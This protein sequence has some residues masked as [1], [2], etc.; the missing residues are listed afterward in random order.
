MTV[1]SLILQFYSYCYRDIH[2]IHVAKLF[3]WR[4]T[5]IH[6]QLFSRSH[7][8]YIHR[9]LIICCGHVFRLCIYRKLNSLE[10]PPPP[11]YW[12]I[13]QVTWEET[14]VNNIF[15]YNSRKLTIYTRFIVKVYTA[16]CSWPL[17]VVA[18]NNFVKNTS[19]HIWKQF[20]RVKNNIYSKSDIL[21]SCYS[22]STALVLQ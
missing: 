1:T 20:T 4:M 11:L 2:P 9:L 19:L 8:L 15:I 10:R 18:R 3:L 14:T 5:S 21:F 6:S 17:L 22:E 7:L 12:L 16:L 13:A